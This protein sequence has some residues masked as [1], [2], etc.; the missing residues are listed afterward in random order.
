ME[1]K[2]DNDKEPELK[3][4]VLVNNIQPKEPEQYT[5]IKLLEQRI[6]DL[7][8][9]VDDLKDAKDLAYLF[10]KHKVIFSIL[11]SCL[12]FAIIWLILYNWNSYKKFNDD[13]F[14]LIKENLET[15]LCILEKTQDVLI[16]NKI[17]RQNNHTTV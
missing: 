10:N 14:N 15:K 16:E 17:N 1:N 11:G 13:K 8:C 3:N 7:E 12:L 6:K 4:D 9:K 5:H 2:Q